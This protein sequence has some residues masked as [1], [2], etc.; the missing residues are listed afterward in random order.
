M[1]CLHFERTLLVKC[2]M[3][4]TLAS[5]QELVLGKG[6]H[7]KVQL[8]CQLCLVRIESEQDLI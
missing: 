8:P 1:H 4:A 6:H 3:I 2:C 7:V 5:C